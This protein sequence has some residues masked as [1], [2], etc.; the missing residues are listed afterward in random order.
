MAEPT[1]AVDTVAVA[2]DD[3]I[4]PKSGVEYPIIITYTF[5]SHYINKGITV[6]DKYGNTYSVKPYPCVMWVCDNNPELVCCFRR[7]FILEWRRL[8][9]MSKFKHLPI[10]W[11][12]PTTEYAEYVKYVEE[13]LYE[14]AFRVDCIKSV[15]FTTQQ[16]LD[17]SVVEY[18]DHLDMYTYTY[19]GDVYVNGKKKVFKVKMSLD[20]SSNSKPN[21]KT[22]FDKI[23]Y[24]GF[25]DDMNGFSRYSM[26][27]R[28]IIHGY[29]MIKDTIWKLGRSG[30]V[31]WGIQLPC[32]CLVCTGIH[33]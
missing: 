1:I 22:I 21:Q 30:G 19:K 17:N 31:N 9:Q 15:C 29:D 7:I 24:C 13:H 20:A 27:V 25:E 28:A 16:V 4:Q 3:N 6:K 26:C 32:T 23:E 18:N 5:D 8:S 14:I 33:R 12:N 2:A 10:P 11:P